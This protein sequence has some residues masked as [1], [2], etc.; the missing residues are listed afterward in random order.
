MGNFFCLV[1]ELLM[2]TENFD[3][4]K[5]LCNNFSSADVVDTPC[6]TSSCF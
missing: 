3:V 4:T 6:S 2:D 5:F 1:F